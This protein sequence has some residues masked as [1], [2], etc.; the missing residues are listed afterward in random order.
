MKKPDMS[1]LCKKRMS[2]SVLITFLVY[3]LGSLD[4]AQ[5]KALN[6][7]PSTEAILLALIAFCS[8]LMRSPLGGGSS[9]DSAAETD[10]S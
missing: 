9:D 7:P 5:V 3:V 4:T 8:C 6:L 10:A 1:N 2:L